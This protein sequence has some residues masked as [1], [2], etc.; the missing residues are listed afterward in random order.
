MVSP[1]LIVVVNYRTPG[2]AIDCLASIAAERTGSS[3]DRVVVVDNA[4]GDGSVDRLREA[5]A[6]RGWSG[7]ASLVASD[8]N[9]GFAAGNN[10]AIREELRRTAGERARYVLLL[11]PDTVIRP[12]AVSE[13]ASFMDAHP[14]AGVA[15]SRVENADGRPQ[16]SARR[17]PSAL[18]ELESTAR[19]GLLSRLLRRHAIPIPEGDHPMRCEWVSGAAMMIRSEVFDAIGLMDE[20]FFLY[21]EET[22][23]CRRAV[24]A[25]WQVWFVPGSRVLH[26]EGSATGI[27]ERNRRRPRYWFESRRRYFVKALGA[28]GWFLADCCWALGRLLWAVRRCAG[29]SRSRDEDPRRLATDLLGG[30]LLEM[31]S[32]RWRRIARAAGDG[33]VK[34]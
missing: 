29:A 5:I 17:F 31:F 2:R 34:A 32:G 13:L 30:D 21:Y 3:A 12:G 16:G 33:P 7:W 4:S 6:A 10:L 8:R 25:G 24:R 9:G 20:E 15:G 11:N 27:R 18:G 28:R 26:H 22:D 1:V 23:F 19:L 14:E